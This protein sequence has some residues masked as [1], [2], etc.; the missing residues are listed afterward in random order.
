MG[1]HLILGNVSAGQPLFVGGEVGKEAFLCKPIHK[2]S[3]K[4]SSKNFDVTRGVIS[5]R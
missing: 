3:S 2:Q 5:E 1:K 4:S